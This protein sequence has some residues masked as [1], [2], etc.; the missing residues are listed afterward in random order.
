MKDLRPRGR[1]TSIVVFV[2][3]DPALMVRTVL[4]WLRS[5]FVSG[6][7]CAC[8]STCLLLHYCSVCQVRNGK[9]QSY[10]DQQYRF[11]FSPLSPD[12]R[13]QWVTSC[14]FRNMIYGRLYQVTNLD[15]QMQCDGSLC[16]VAGT[17]HGGCLAHR[18]HLIL[19]WL[20]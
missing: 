12:C 11:R 13:M 18:L 20:Y 16:L 14:Y 15:I 3:G 1:H 17:V 9:W 8:V 7:V 10:Q 5:C 4:C 2:W 6:A 19:V